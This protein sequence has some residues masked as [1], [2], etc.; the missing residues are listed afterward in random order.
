MFEIIFP[1]CGTKANSNSNIISQRRNC[2]H[3]GNFISP[4]MPSAKRGVSCPLNAN[5]P[6]Q[7][8][9]YQ[10]QGVGGTRPLREFHGLAP[11][12]HQ[13]QQQQRQQQPPHFSGLAQRGPTHPGCIMPGQ[14]QKQHQ[15]Q[16][17]NTPVDVAVGAARLGQQQQHSSNIA[18]TIV[19]T[20]NTLTTSSNGSSITVNNNN[21]NVVNANDDGVEIPSPTIS[22]SPMEVCRLHVDHP[23]KIIRCVSSL[24]SVRYMYSMDLY[25]EAVNFLGGNFTGANMSTD[26]NLKHREELAKMY[27]DLILASIRVGKPETCRVLLRDMARFKVPR[28]LGLWTSIVKMCTSK[29]YFA[30]SLRVHEIMV[31]ENVDIQE[32]SIW[33]CLLFCAVE[34]NCLTKCMSF[35]ESIKRCGMP[36]VKDFGNIIR[37]L[38]VSGDWQRSLELL[39]DMTKSGIPPDNVAY[40]TVLSICSNAREVTNTIEISNF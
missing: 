17:N 26:E 34:A 29:H 23:T 31:Q 16:H 30:E 20:A 24:S 5:G 2:T 32:R 18:S 38:A 36:S 8:F 28:S 7:G 25:K 9:G 22:S 6:A 27:E 1:T 3:N 15:H 40:N 4:L 35:F 14:Q 11:P 21:N 33:S 39:D 37:V 12:M 13:G 19:N 10:H